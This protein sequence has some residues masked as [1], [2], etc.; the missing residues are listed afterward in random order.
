MKKKSRPTDGGGNWMDTY[1]DM[2]TLLLTFFIM[3]YSMSTVDAQ[4]WNVFVKSLGNTEEQSDDA[5]TI[6]EEYSEVPE[7]HETGDVGDEEIAKNNEV[8]DVSTLYLT[9][10][11]ALSAAEIDGAT[12]I[13]GDDY[14]YV[15]FS[16]NVFFAANSYKLTDE[17]AA[18]MRLFS[19]AIAPAAEQ[20][21]QISIMSHTAK[22]SQNSEIDPEII[23]KDRML[24]AMRGATICVFLQEQQIIQ[25]SKLVDISYGEYRPIADNATAAGRVKNRR[26]EFLLLDRGA[27]QKGLDEYYSDFKSGKYRE[28]T[29][30]TVGGSESE[31]ETDTKNPGE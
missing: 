10:A 11:R 3:L 12:V 25:P 18:V 16:N 5:F 9:I 30:L 28:T 22:A 17:G 6:N 2:V 1:G 8:E 19:Q 26:I 7:K 21:E 29:I 4:K 20:I 27:K 31:S 24:S 15:S 14:T 23:R 13:R